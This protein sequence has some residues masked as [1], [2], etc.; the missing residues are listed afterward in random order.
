M[1][2]FRRN[3]LN[4]VVIV[5]HGFVAANS[6]G[7]TYR[8]R[9][10]HFIMHINYMQNLGYQFVSPTQ[11]SA[12]R[13]GAWTPAGPIACIQFDD[14]LASISLAAIWLMQNKIPFSVAIIGRRLHLRN[15]EGDFISWA[16]LQ[17]YVASGL[18]EIMSHT[19]NLHHL[20]ISDVA[21]DTQPIMQGPWWNDNGMVF[22]KKAGDTRN[23][24]DWSYIEGVSWGLPIM[25][26]DAATLTPQGG[27]TAGSTPITTAITFNATLSMTV[28]LIRFWAALG[29]PAGAGYAVSLHVTVG[30]TLVF[31]G[32]IE[33]TAYPTR[34]QWKERE[35]VTLQLTTPFA[36]VAGTS[37]TLTFATQNIGP[38]L[39]RCYALPDFTGNFSCTSNCVSVVPGVNNVTTMIDYPAGS[40]MPAVPV[41]ILGDGT[42]ALVSTATFD[43]AIQADL[44]TNNQAINQYLAAVWTEHD[45]GYFEESPLLYV[46]VAF[47]TYLDGT[48]VDSQFLYV[49]DVP[50]TAYTLAFKFVA[51]LG[52]YYPIQ[53]GCYIGTSH[54]GPWTLVATFAPNYTDY[55]WQ[56]IT[57]DTP[58]TFGGGNYWIRFLTNNACPYTGQASLLR[59]YVDQY[60][61]VPYVYGFGTA[62]AA[63]YLQNTGSDIYASNYAV[64]RP[65][66]KTFS[67]VAGSSG[68]P[69]RIV[70]PFGAYDEAASGPAI[71]TNTQ[72]ISAGMKAVMAACG[73]VDGQGTWPS[74]NHVDG[75]L[76]EP[77]IRK[78]KWAMARLLIY[79]DAPIATS[80]NNLAAFCG[81]LWP[82]A[83]HGGVKWQTSLEPDAGGNATI[84]YAYGALKFVGF[85]AYS[86]NAAG[87][88]YKS[89]L[90]DGRTYITFSAA[91]TGT[92][93][94][95]QSIS[96]PSGSGVVEWF[97]G[98]AN[99]S[100]CSITGFS[101]SFTAGESWATGTGHGAVS[102]VAAYPNDKTFL[103]SRG[104]K[105]LLYV[106]NF[107]YA[108]GDF[109]GA[110]AHTVVSA[111]SGYVTALVAAVTA[112]GWDGAII[113]IENVLQTDRAAATAFIL[114]AADA[115]HAIRKECH[116]AVPAITGTS[117]DLVATW[118]G[119]CDYATLVQ[120]VDMMH[121]MTYT[122][123][124]GSTTAI[125]HAPQ[126]FWNEVYQYV[127]TTIPYRFR[128][129]VL[130]GCNAFSDTWTG[131]VDTNTDYW[132]GLAQGFL[133]E[134]LMS[135]QD[136]ENTWSNF[137]SA[138][139]M[140]TPATMSRAVNQALADGF[141]GI[142][143]W[144]ADD[145]D[146]FSFFPQ[147]P[148]I[149]RV[150][151]EG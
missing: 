68:S 87:G 85:D 35:F 26:T 13:S 102:E 47:G 73:F 147:Y 43:A 150:L 130:V 80:L 126:W 133:V 131:G 48:K 66:I 91:I 101:G 54:T 121:I 137:G 125:P 4:N 12:W 116:I 95:A 56:E 5:Y 94:A 79:G 53:A 76:D 59:I 97:N 118:T 75:L 149:G 21:G 38:G 110:L 146:R 111:Y 33:P 124:A 10:D 7:L 99:H 30:A 52:D 144:K 119:W 50:H 70:Y 113:D 112:D 51:N 141:A 46:G 34:S 143:S 117:Y 44:L 8:E 88:I 62:P 24:W 145:G 93:S 120:R 105:C 151:N 39:M 77:G 109:D 1:A 9:M 3:G 25:G 31:A 27:V 128:C 69:T 60:G 41:M 16:T 14:G 20:N 82:D 81:A 89:R 138:A 122:E 36:V 106:T 86:F 142:G 65:F 29:V 135:N 139:F 107:N 22:H 115:L 71:L 6:V 55:G 127:L 2:S 114:A 136:A 49:P 96:G 45:N 140:G 67:Y 17:G 11:Y 83:Q 132:D 28:S 103:Q 74:V 92:I 58:Y 42:G 19:Y 63:Y 37:Y 15:P 40:A 108:L 90:N 100:I 72:D 84:R 78:T 104:I 148:Q 64:G 98:D 18:C 57:L 32:V 123:N 134:G 129:R 23:W 61:A